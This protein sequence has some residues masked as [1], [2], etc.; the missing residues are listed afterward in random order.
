MLMDV[1]EDDPLP[2]RD[3]VSF[4]LRKGGDQIFPFILNTPE[5]TGPYWLHRFI[6][7]K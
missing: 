7:P 6:F 4:V 1:M 2:H 3:G 5:H